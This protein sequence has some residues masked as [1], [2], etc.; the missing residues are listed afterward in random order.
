VT[1]PALIPAR[2]AGAEERQASAA[3]PGLR[4]V[5]ADILGEGV[6]QV[7]S[8]GGVIAGDQAG[9]GVAASWIRT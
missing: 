2:A 7:A 3:A 5:C 6:D 8:P 4:Q 9:S 1:G